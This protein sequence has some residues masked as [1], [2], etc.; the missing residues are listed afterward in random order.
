M[1]RGIEK[2]KRKIEGI[3]SHRKTTEERM[4]EPVETLPYH[5]FTSPSGFKVFVGKNRRGNEVV[6]FKLAGP[7]DYFFHVKDAPGAH[8]IM[9]TGKREPE[10][11][12]IYFAAC[13]ALQFSK[14]KRE[15]KGIVTYTKKK[16]VRRPPGAQPGLV[17]LREEKTI[18]VRL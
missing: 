1:R 15:G 12:D 18:Q 14:L 9:K 2:L 11:E 13:L 3:E 8:V 5:T 6:T 7:E 16:H 10:E 4:E 17:T